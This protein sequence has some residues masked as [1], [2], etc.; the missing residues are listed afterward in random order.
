M[1][2]TFQKKATKRKNC[3]TT[4]LDSI[5]RTNRWRTSPSCRFSSTRNF[6]RHSPNRLAM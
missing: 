4:S 1:Q 5:L 6:T 3:K 2:N